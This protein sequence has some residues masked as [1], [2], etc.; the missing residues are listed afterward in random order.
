MPYPSTSCGQATPLAVF[1][2]FEHSTPRLTSMHFALPGGN[3]RR[4]T[5]DG[6]TDGAQRHD[7]PSPEALRQPAPGD[8]R[9]D[10]AVEE[11]GE[12]RPLRPRVP[13]Q[14]TR[15]RGTVDF[16]GSQVEVS[17]VHHGDDGD[18]QRD[19]LERQGEGAQGRQ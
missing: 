9:E 10:V 1:Y 11:G 18:G 6:R 12:E 16:G 13:R 8:L 19:A 2:S 7:A 4:Q 17:L 3:R 5:Q 14:L 15:G